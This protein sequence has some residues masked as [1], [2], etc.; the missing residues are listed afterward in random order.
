VSV[1]LF[2]LNFFPVAPIDTR[3]PP[4]YPDNHCGDQECWLL[5]SKLSR[6]EV[7]DQGGWF[8]SEGV[9]NVPAVFASGGENGAEG[10]EDGCPCCCAEAACDFLFAFDHA[11]I[12]FSLIVRERH[13]WIEQETQ[14]VILVTVQAQQ[15]I[16]SCATAWA[17]TVFCAARLQRRHAFMVRK[18]LCQNAVIACKRLRT[19]AERAVTNACG[20]PDEKTRFYF[21]IILKA[22]E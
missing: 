13:G 8:L 5:P 11:D 15:Q 7:K 10:R 1:H 17:S 9:K 22:L 6:F 18:A 2:L 20:Q 12:T 14:R 19:C 3:Y 21:F 16:M 4:M